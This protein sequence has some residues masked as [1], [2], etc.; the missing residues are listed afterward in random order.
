MD[1]IGQD[2]TG[3][4]RTGQVMISVLIGCV[5]DSIGPFDLT[6]QTHE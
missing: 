2:M 1:R 6:S 5:G 4:E 3:W